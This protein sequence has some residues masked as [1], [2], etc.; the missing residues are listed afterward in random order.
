MK[1]TLAIIEQLHA[2]GV[3]GPYAIG[4]AVAAAFYLEPDATL[5]VDVFPSTFHSLRSAEK[6]EYSGSWPLAGLR[7]FSF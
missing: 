5:D 2:D 1:E 3:I 7:T 6:I 4:G